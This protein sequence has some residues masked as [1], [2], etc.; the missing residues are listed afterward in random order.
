[1]SGPYQEPPL[2]AG[3]QAALLHT[4]DAVAHHTGVGGLQFWPRGDG[5][6]EWLA[7]IGSSYKTIKVHW[8]CALPA[9]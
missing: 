1:M 3:L 2:A 8:C 9:G 6:Y 4:I 7:S 5:K